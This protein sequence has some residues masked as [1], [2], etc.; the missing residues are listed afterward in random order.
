[1]PAKPSTSAPT[2]YSAAS[3][4]VSF[5]LHAMNSGG[6]GSCAGRGRIG[7]GAIVS[8]PSHENSS[9]SHMLAIMRSDSST[10]R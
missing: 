8:S 6:W 9:S 3:V 7:C 4:T 5:L 10:S 2:P 1:M